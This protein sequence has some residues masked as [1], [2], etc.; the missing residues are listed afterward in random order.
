M[1]SQAGSLFKQ[2]QVRLTQG[3]NVPRRNYR[4]TLQLIRLEAEIDERDLLLRRRES[5][6]VSLKARLETEVVKSEERLRE[7]QA[8]LDK[9]T[10]TLG[11][12]LLRHY[13]RLKYRFL[14]PAYRLLRSGGS[15]QEMPRSK[16]E[17]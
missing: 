10:N 15:R 7:K 14:L 2:P 12:R 6:L 17:S 9:I 3:R 13:G 4:D 11:W 1:C 16:P 5:D 8:E